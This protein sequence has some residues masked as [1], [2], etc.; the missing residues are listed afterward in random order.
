MQDNIFH[1]LAA[2]SE[3]VNFD[4]CTDLSTSITL[5]RARSF[6]WLNGFYLH[7]SGPRAAELL[8]SIRQVTYKFKPFETECITVSQ[9]EELCNAQGYETS[10]GRSPTFP[11][12]EQ[13]IGNF[14]IDDLEYDATTTCIALSANLYGS[15][16]GPGIPVVALVWCPL[17]FEFNYSADIIGA[18]QA[19]ELTLSLVVHEY[20]FCNLDIRAEHAVRRHTKQVLGTMFVIDDGMVKVEAA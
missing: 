17:Q 9:G 8:N 4:A 1:T 3:K 20:G 14:G 12:M 13:T 16:A 7:T 18:V 11:H 6:D 19:G 15:D 10:V 2:R 5:S